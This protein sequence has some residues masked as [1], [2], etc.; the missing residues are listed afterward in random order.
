MLQQTNGED[1]RKTR[2]QA[3]V[4]WKACTIAAGARNRDANMEVRVFGILWACDRFLKQNTHAVCRVISIPTSH[5]LGTTRLTV[6]GYASPI[7]KE[8]APAAEAGSRSSWLPEEIKAA[9]AAAAPPRISNPAPPPS[10]AP[11]CAGPPRAP[12]VG[13]AETLLN[14]RD[15]S[16]TRRVF[17][18]SIARAATRAFMAAETQEQNKTRGPQARLNSTCRQKTTM[19]SFDDMKGT[20]KR[21]VMNLLAVHQSNRHS[22]GELRPMET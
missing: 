3:I 13:R 2:E 16:N 15:I 10:P 5:R 19:T 17:N 14:V 22:R 6:L 11:P 7:G 1:R 9:V 21:G 12:V 4:L 20:I 18:R 8:Y